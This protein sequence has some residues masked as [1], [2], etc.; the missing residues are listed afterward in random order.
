MLATAVVCLPLGAILGGASGFNGALVGAGFVFVFA[1]VAAA[2]HVVAAPLQG[3]AAWM[4]AVLGGL[5]AR[6]AIY[7][8]GLRLFGE[9]AMLSDVALGLTALFGIVIGQI[10]ETRAL[11]RTP[12]N[13]DVRLSAA[14]RRPTNRTAPQTTSG[15]DD[16]SDRHGQGVDR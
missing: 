13:R 8:L 5:A 14:Q 9:V 7:V 2:V 15:A 12:A 3:D 6:V 11:L 4:V 16:G 10:L 1:V